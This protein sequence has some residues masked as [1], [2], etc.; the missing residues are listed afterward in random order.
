[1]EWIKRAT[2]RD[3]YYYPPL[4]ATHNLDLETGEFVGK[5]PQTTRPAH[6][7]HLPTSH[8]LE[9]RHPKQES[10]RSFSDQALIIHALAF[11]FGTRLQFKEWR[12]EGRVPIKPTNNWSIR[13][14]TRQD[15]LNRAYQYWRSL[16][17]E[18]RTRLIN[19]LYMT[20]RARS[21]EWDWESFSQAYMVVDA[22]F[23]VLVRQQVLNRKIPHSRRIKEMCE[24]FDITYDSELLQII[25]RT[26]NELFHEALWTGKIAG[27]SLALGRAH[28][29]HKHMGRLIERLICGLIGYRNE[30]SRSSWWH[31]GTLHFDRW[32]P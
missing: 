5:A 19:I 6:V 24:C 11:L 29:I 16:P 32:K 17:R 7:Y 27:S 14:E 23:D 18:T 8:W 25:Q 22:I 26:R 20:N 12:M 15:V 2:N 28:L 1:M 9:V 21:L 31:M 10:E 3:G 30:F 13:D 4:I